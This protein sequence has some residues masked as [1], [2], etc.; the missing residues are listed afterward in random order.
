MSKFVATNP[1]TKKPFEAA[2]A[3]KQEFILLF[4]KR[5]PYDGWF[6]NEVRD[7]VV[8]DMIEEVAG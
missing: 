5:A 3:S 2:A 6:P 8:Q 4:V 1:K 7:C